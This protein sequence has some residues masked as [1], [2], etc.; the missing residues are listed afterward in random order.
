MKTFL[1][2]L[3]TPWM[4]ENL[5]STFKY[6]LNQ[7]NPSY[8]MQIQYFSQPIKT[9]LYTIITS[10]NENLP[11]ICKYS[12]QP[13]KTFL[14]QYMQILLS[15]NE[16]LPIICKYSPE[17]IKFFLFHQPMKTFILYANTPLNQWH[18][19]IICKYSSQLIKT[20]LLYANL[21]LSQS[22]P[23]YYM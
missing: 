15:T 17:P 3:N 14:L 16:N 9:F 20:F 10:T 4:N 21:P 6:S 12:P 1:A 13:M 23:S 2:H 7:W 19:P 22:K 8:Y 11:I 5:P 18:L